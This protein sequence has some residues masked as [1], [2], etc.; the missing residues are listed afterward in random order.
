MLIMNLNLCRNDVIIHI[1]VRI[2]QLFEGSPSNWIVTEDGAQILPEVF[3]QKAPYEDGRVDERN[4][5]ATSD[6]RREKAR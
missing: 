3:L 5:S 1:F 2:L 6:R 4:G